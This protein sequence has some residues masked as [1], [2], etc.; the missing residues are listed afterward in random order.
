MRSV[1]HSPRAGR[2]E[3]INLFRGLAAIRDSRIAALIIFGIRGAQ[4]ARSASRSVI[5]TPHRFARDYTVCATLAGRTCLREWEQDRGAPRTSTQR[6][7]YKRELSQ[8]RWVI[9][10]RAL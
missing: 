4:P 10:N 8:L 9:R 7:G 1:G 2:I 3:S 5:S 6:A